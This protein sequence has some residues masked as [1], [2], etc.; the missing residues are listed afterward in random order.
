[1][2]PRDA[3]APPPAGSPRPTA[4]EALDTL[5]ALLATSFPLEPGAG[6]CV[7][8]AFLAAAL[9]AAQQMKQRLMVLCGRVTR[10]AARP[11]PTSQPTCSSRRRSPP[12]ASGTSGACTPSRS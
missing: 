10:S 7:A 4:L 3:H 11:S 2:F 5:N 12:A 9:R 1:M 8:V 6:R